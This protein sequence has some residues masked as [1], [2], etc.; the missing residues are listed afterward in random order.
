M[1]IHYKDFLFRSDHFVG[2]E[3]PKRFTANV[4]GVVK[5]TPE[6]LEVN[7][8]RVTYDGKEI[9]SHLKA[10]NERELEIQLRSF[11]LNEARKG[12][13]GDAYAAD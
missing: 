8:L 11:Y 7:V 13:E 6:A 5:P 3:L 12:L 2:L 1:E 10:E 4:Y 9:A